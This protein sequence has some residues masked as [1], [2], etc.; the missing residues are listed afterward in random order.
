MN[1]IFIISFLL[2]S[3]T[4]H[5]IATYNFK[6]PNTVLSSLSPDSTTGASEDENPNRDQNPETMPSWGKLHQYAHV[7][8]RLSDRILFIYFHEGKIFS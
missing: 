7:K 3:V 1:Y 6:V 2:A 8:G 5:I 4:T